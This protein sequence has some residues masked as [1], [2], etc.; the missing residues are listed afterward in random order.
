MSKRMPHSPPLPSIPCVSVLGVGSELTSGQITNKNGSWISKKLHHFGL[1]SNLHLVVPDERS[2]ITKALDFCASESD[3]IFV[4]GGL[5][6]TSDDFTRDLICEWAGLEVDFDEGSWK[7]VVDRLSSRGFAVQDFQKQQCYFPQGS[8]ILENQQGTANGFYVY[9]RS[10]HF[11]VLP[12][13]PREIEAIWNDH[14]QSWLKENTQHIDPLVTKSW[15]TIG[16]GESEVA[17]K[18][19]AVTTAAKSKLE[20][21][22]RVHLPYV[23]VKATYHQSEFADISSTLEKI[24]QTLAA[25]TVLRNSE[26]IAE[27][28]CQRL[29]NYEKVYIQDEATD[30]FLAHRIQN[31]WKQ[32]LRQTELH[33]SNKITSLKL[34]DLDSKKSQVLAV[35]LRR[36]EPHLAESSLM[37]SVKG[38]GQK[39]GLNHKLQSPYQTDNMIERSR[40]MFAE[41]ALIEWIKNI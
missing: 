17:R 36:L 39:I 2:L 18:T 12:G 38:H 1:K 8:W 22:Y 11:F 41:L 37:I 25:I 21:G 33:F 34:A 13:P 32:V 40:Q 3:L 28:F 23:E 26:D 4:T 20:I 16:E 10:K 19:E 27:I 35:Q 15:D 6:P 5:G 29:L 30:G 31:H 9:A 24:D 7:K 14:I